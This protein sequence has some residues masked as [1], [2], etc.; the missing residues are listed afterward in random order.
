MQIQMV[1]YSN[2]VPPFDAVNVAPLQSQTEIPARLTDSLPISHALH[3]PKGVLVHL[4]EQAVL[5]F[6]ELRYTWAVQVEDSGARDI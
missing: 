4:I 3:H 5:R 2:G 6:G 1:T